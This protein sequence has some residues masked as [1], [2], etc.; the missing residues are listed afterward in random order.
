MP[1]AARFPTAPRTASFSSPPRRNQTRKARA[2]QG[3]RATA[4][5]RSSPGGIDSHGYP[6]PPL[7]S[8]SP[9][10]PSTKPSKAPIVPNSISQHLSPY[11]EESGYLLQKL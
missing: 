11:E 2:A 6:S 7:S 3:P 1:T 5:R 4:A 9:F 8:S 10:G